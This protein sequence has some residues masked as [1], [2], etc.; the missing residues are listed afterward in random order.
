MTSSRKPHRYV[1]L[2]RFAALLDLQPQAA[3]HRLNSGLLPTPDVYV[4]RVVLAGKAIPG[5]TAQRV[6][7]YREFIAQFLVQPSN[8][9]RL[10]SG[11]PLPDW[12]DTTPEWFLNQREAAK[13]V[14]LQPVSVSARLARGTFPVAP[15][16]V[17]G[18]RH[19][20]IANGW[21]LADLRR[22]CQGAD[23]DRRGAPR[24]ADDP[25]FY[26]R[27]AQ[28]RAKAAQAA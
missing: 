19:H 28:A 9:L 14:G 17:V 6:R 7:A 24:K 15:R 23:K 27:R 18:E 10:P 3:H 26:A 16:V 20:G 2:A 8:R 5:W 4:G 13:I 21:E 11:L 1:N 25:E 22:H 12:W